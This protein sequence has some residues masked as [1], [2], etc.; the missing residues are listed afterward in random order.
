MNALYRATPALWDLDFSPEG[1]E[2]IV[3]D[4]AEDNTVGV[5]AQGLVWEILAAVS[6]FSPVVR[7][8]YRIWPSICG[9]V[10]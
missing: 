3:S 4:A 8:G 7:E 9:P 5:A 1:F 10:A 2:W 6:N